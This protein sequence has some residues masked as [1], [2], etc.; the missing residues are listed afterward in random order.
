MFTKRQKIMLSYI[1]CA[2]EELRIDILAEIIHVSVQT[3]RSELEKIN[4]ILP[5]IGAHIVM[6]ARGGCLIAEEDREP[7]FHLLQST[8]TVDKSNIE[9]HAVWERII[10]S[11][12]ML[13]FE[14]DYVS[15]EELAE[16]LY[17]SKSTMNLD[18]SEVKRIIGRTAG[19]SLHIS[20]TSGLKIQ[21]KETEIR[22]LLSKMI[23]QGLELDVAVRHVFPDVQLGEIAD[24]DTIQ[25]LVRS[26]LVKRGHLITGKA[27]GLVCADILVSAVRNYLGF[28]ISAD[29]AQAGAG[30]PENV[31][32]T[33][34]SSGKESV[35]TEE[36]MTARKPPHPLVAELAARLAGELGIVFTSEDIAYLQRTVMEQNLFYAGGEAGPRDREAADV[37]YDALR[38]WAGLDLGA[39]GE[40][41]SRFL[42]Y[43]NQLNQRVDN[44]H[45]YTNF[46]KRQTNRLFPLTASVVAHCG[47][48]LHD[49][50]FRYSEA[51]L[52]Y[53]VLVLGNRFEVE[54]PELRV[55]LIS[56][57]H[58]ALVGWIEAEL[59][60]TL[61]D[62]MLEVTSMPRYLYE[63]NKREA[64]GRFDLAL[65][66]EPIAADADM[67]TI[68]VYSL[69]GETETRLLRVQLDHYLRRHEKN[70]LK[71]IERRL[72]GPSR[73][74]LL[75][76]AGG[77]ERGI[78]ELLGGDGCCG[79]E[80][81]TLLQSHMIPTD[82]RIAY[83]SVL[84]Q[85]GGSSIH[86]GKLSKPVVHKAKTLHTLIVSVFDSADRAEAASFYRCVCYLLDPR[87]GDRWGKIKNYTDFVGAF[88]E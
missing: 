84:T 87:H 42:F 55:L 39:Y 31:N 83:I 67:E 43:L 20:K 14:R 77:L 45:D 38:T 63:E 47:A 81:E 4:D 15:M 7:I 21:G 17:V 5:Q 53:I 9:N 34:T 27:F 13:V 50:G 58:T 33:G 32:E 41:N 29:E 59:H 10:A 37:F 60:R 56:D 25:A 57:E 72:I 71:A 66:T 70:R 2:K 74:R 28:R 79:L 78:A 35:R 24:Y 18:I 6:T 68:F 73:F 86:I 65:T 51:E 30:L 40:F 76:E 26:L 75:V 61:G 1:Y 69:L 12:G 23:H 62:T 22:Y 19:V 49:R 52:A 11:I 54:H 82:V 88:F 3:A 64:A 36:S 8:A 48:L 85:G 80:P 44:G 16:R 46:F